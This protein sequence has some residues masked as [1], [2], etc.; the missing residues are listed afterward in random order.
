V[1]GGF[2]MLPVDS[3]ILPAPP[4]RVIRTRLSWPQ[5]TPDFPPRNDFGGT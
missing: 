4:Q 5:V 1:S 2:D 3:D